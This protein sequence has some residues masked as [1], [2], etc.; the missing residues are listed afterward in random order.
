VLLLLGIIRP[1]GE[2]CR[3]SL[4][5]ATRPDFKREMSGCYLGEKAVRVE[6]GAA[7]M[8]VGEREQLERCTLEKM[9]AGRWISDNVERYLYDMSVFTACVFVQLVD[10]SEARAV[11]KSS[12]RF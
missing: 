5:S 11:A 10:M 7:A 8:D 9:E 6:P 2:G 1:V 3:A 4:F 12:G